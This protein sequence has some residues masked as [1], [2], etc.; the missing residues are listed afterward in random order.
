[1]I[2]NIAYFPSLQSVHFDKNTKRL[3]FNAHLLEKRVSESYEVLTVHEL[4]LFGRGADLNFSFDALQDHRNYLQDFAESNTA[5]SSV[6]L[7]FYSLK[8]EQWV[9]SIVKN[10]CLVTRHL[11]LSGTNLRVALHL[12]GNKELEEID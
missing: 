8:D 6:V 3:V 9:L 4:A 12:C 2:K 7:N 5:I 10:F 11:F 1:M